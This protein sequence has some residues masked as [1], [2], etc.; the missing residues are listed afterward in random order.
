M[1]V[2]LNPRTS[3]LWLI[4][5]VTRKTSIGRHNI[6]DTNLGTNYHCLLVLACTIDKIDSRTLRVPMV[7]HA[8][9]SSIDTSYRLTRFVK[10]CRASNGG[11]PDSVGPKN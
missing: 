9:T 6:T 1:I 2:S 8:R 7:A 5:K 11:G 4:G 3:V 10:C